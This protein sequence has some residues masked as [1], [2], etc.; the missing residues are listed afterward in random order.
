MQSAARPRPVGG[1]PQSQARLPPPVFGMSTPGRATPRKGP[2]NS[3]LP[4]HAASATPFA[5][6]TT[7]TP[8]RPLRGFSHLQNG[9]DTASPAPAKRARTEAKSPSRDP[10]S[11]P[12]RRTPSK[13]KGKTKVVEVRSS[14]R[15]SSPAEN[16]D[17]EM[18]DWNGET[19]LVDDTG[20]EALDLEDGYALAADERAEVCSHVGKRRADGRR[21]YKSYSQASTQIHGLMT[22]GNLLCNRSCTATSTLCRTRTCRTCTRLSQ[23]FSMVVGRQAKMPTSW[24]DWLSPR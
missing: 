3:M 1:T 16:E 10:P 20:I 14:P 12:L 9:F 18:D 7:A 23:T 4:A 2:V 21:C 19:E 17:V 5:R 13:G 24:P 22:T 11:S 8:A 6:R 15:Q